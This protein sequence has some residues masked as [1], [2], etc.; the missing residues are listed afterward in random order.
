[1]ISLLGSFLQAHATRPWAPGAVD[2]CLVLADWAMAL[3]HDDPAT[4]LRGAYD[5]EAGFFEI[6]ERSGGVVPLVGSC[7]SHVGFLIKAEARCGDIGVIGSPLNMR[8]QFGAI[9][10]GSRWWVRNAQGF[11][12]MTARKLASWRIECL[13]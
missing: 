10:D 11:V 5:D 8:R 9:F 12:P 6:I 13:K 2:C 3:G 4:Y 1:M 7:V